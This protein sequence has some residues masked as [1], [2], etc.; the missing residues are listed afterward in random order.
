MYRCIHKVRWRSMFS[1]QARPSCSHT[2]LN[3]RTL[4]I[5]PERWYPRMSKDFQCI[6]AYVPNHIK[7]YI[8]ENMKMT[9][10][11]K[12]TGLYCVLQA[13]RFSPTLPYIPLTN[14]SYCHRSRRLPVT[15]VT[16]EFP[17]PSCHLP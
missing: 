12:H 9:H 16:G 8:Y 17:F 1:S 4:N 2:I 10:T 5:L 14:P 3:R 6:L 7:P 15:A 11:Y 13:W